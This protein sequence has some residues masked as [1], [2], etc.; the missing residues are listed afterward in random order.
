[1]IFLILFYQA[2]G[3][4]IEAAES[5]FENVFQVREVDDQGAEDDDDEDSD[6]TLTLCDEDLSDCDVLLETLDADTENA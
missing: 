3:N 1:M 2:L 5:D 4:W 6:D